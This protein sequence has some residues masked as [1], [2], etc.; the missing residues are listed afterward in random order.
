M[1]IHDNQIDQLIPLMTIDNQ[2]RYEYVKTFMRD[3]FQ[4]EDLDDSQLIIEP[5]TTQG[6]INFVFSILMKYETPSEYRDIIRADKD[7]YY[8]DAEDLF[9]IQEMNCG[10]TEIINQYLDKLKVDKEDNE[11]IIISCSQF[12]QLLSGFVIE[13]KKYNNQIPTNLPG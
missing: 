4:I 10:E 12:K 5:I 13:Y 1:K 9:S 8:L 2:N 3:N 6:F 7:T 11:D